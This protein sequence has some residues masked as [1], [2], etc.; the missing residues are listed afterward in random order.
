METVQVERD[1]GIAILRLNRP[2]ALNALSRDLLSELD[3]SIAALSQDDSVLATILTGAGDRAFAAGADIKELSQLSQDR[4]REVSRFGQAVFRRIETMNKPVIA[5]VN[6]FALGGGCELAMACSFRLASSKAKFGLPELGL[7]L[8]PGY[9]GT[10][11]LARLVGKG[12]AMEVIL[13]GDMIDASRALQIGLVN[14]VVEPDELLSRAREL[15]LRIAKNAP[16][17]IRFAMESINR[18]LEMSQIQG[19]EYEA[20]LFGMLAASED[21]HEGTRAFLEKRK[22]EF[23]GK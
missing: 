1:G 20:T 23:K 17:A 4:G 22:A 12:A 14:L 16:R 11:R 5:A 13:T 6:G 10:Q 15:A 19:E 2:K 9:G 21:A 8:I 7:G 18:G 3:A